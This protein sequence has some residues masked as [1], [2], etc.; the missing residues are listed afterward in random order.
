MSDIDVKQIDILRTY[1]SKLGDF[2]TGCT[3]VGALIDKQIR[4]IKD[5][6]ASTANDARVA[7][8]YSADYVDEVT[9]RYDRALSKCNNARAYI[10]ET[11]LECKSMYSEAEVLKT[12]IDGHIRDLMTELDN[13]GLHTK[14]FCLQVLNM[15]DGCQTQM[16]NNISALENYLSQN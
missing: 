15:V 4:S 14:N 12:Q 2:K 13:A 11:D 16:N 7:L 9:R 5:D 10:G 3:V 8:E 1:T 6:V